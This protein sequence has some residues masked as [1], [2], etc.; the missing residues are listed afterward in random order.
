MST[1]PNDRAATLAELRERKAEREKARKVDNENAEIER[2]TLE[3]KFETELGGPVGRAFDIVDASGLGEGYVVL[4]LGEAALLNAFM[5]AKENDAVTTE[6]F[7][8][9]NVVHPTRDEYRKLVMR[10]PVIAA[11][12]AGALVEL[13]GLKAKD[14]Q[15]K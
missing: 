12:C 3:E 2:L 14:D 7:V 4:K 5:S 1:E 13:Y 10:R 6:A 15:G 9:P 11:R 8:L